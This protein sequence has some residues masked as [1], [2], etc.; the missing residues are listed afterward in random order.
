M[1]LPLLVLLSLARFFTVECED[2]TCGPNEE[3]DLVDYLIVG[4]GGSGIQMAL[5]LEKY[6]YSYTLLEKALVP[7]SFW[8]EFPVFRELISVNKLVRNETQRFRFDWH[9]M[10]ETPVQMW[11]VTQDYF[12]TGEDWQEYMNRVV[13]DAGISIEYG[14]EVKAI[15][16]NN[17]PC[18]TLMDGSV[19]CARYRVFVGTGL[20]E[21]REPY[22]RAI[23]GIPYSAVTKDLVRFKRVCILGNGNAGFET[24]QNI[25]GVAERVILYGKHLRKFFLSSY[26][27]A[28]QGLQ[29]SPL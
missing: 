16:S 7:G 10:L 27:R 25:I 29:S 12:P 3:C 15:A 14:V 6:D 28:R 26:P 5:F 11:D 22:L 2:T 18:V 17:Q 9:S 23:G 8:K 4:A 21:K 1:R 13:D 19:R 24:A 20:R